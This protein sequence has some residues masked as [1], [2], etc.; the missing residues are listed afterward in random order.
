MGRPAKPRALKAIAGTIQPCR[1]IPPAIELPVISIEE[2]PAAPDW[3]PNSH[4]VKEWDRLAP[5][6]AA[7]K[8]LTQGGLSALGMLCAVHG[9]IVQLFAAGECPNAA[10][11]AQYHTAV[12]AFGLT[13]AAQGKIK[14]L[15]ATP[16]TPANKF[17][18]NGK[19]AA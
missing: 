9:K 15:A 19:R 7:N 10:M 17:S 14:A 1:D 8:L 6:L 5:I 3:L 13:P 18:A 12:T 16:D 11:L 4:A 2:L